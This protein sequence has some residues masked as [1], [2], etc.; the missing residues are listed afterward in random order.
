MIYHISNK[1]QDRIN[2]VYQYN[3]NQSLFYI[4]F[5]FLV[6]L[7]KNPQHM[8]NSCNHLL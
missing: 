5:H 8:H 1:S 7:F 3:L 2:R 6:N 4:K